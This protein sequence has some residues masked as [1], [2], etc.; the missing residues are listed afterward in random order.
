MKSEK[1]YLGFDIG[2]T[3]C[4]VILGTS[5]GKIIDKETFPTG[6][7]PEPYLML[8]KLSDAAN[9][10]IEKNGFGYGKTSGNKTVSA[11]GI[12]CGGPL[13][14]RSGLILSPPNLPGWDEFPI[15][16]IIEKKFNFPVYLQNDANASALAEFMFGA[17]RGFKNIIFLTFGT[18]MG[19]GLILNGRLYEGTNDMAGEIGHVRMEPSGPIGY[20]KAGSFEGFCSGGGIAQLGRIRAGELLMQGKPVPFLK[21][22]QSPEDLTARDIAEKALAG[23]KESLEIYKTSGRYLGMGLSVLIDI[24]NPQRIII[25]SIFGR[26]KDII[27]PEAEQI[28]KKEALA[29]SAGVCQIVPSPLGESIGDL[30]SIAVAVYEEKNLIL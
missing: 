7:A 9:R 11:A 6:S 3:K 14:S 2:G 28:I 24:L 27:Y 30:A 4:A 12:S 13:D 22:G 23:E 20:G 21:K 25:G 26:M 10:I 1:Y 5:S 18:G 17:G 15:V 29:R 19:A 8:E 16:E